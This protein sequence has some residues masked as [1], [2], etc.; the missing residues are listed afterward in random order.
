M[1]TRAG[2]TRCEADGTCWLRDG[3]TGGRLKTL[4]GNCTRTRFGN[5]YL[6]KMANLTGTD[7][8]C[9]DAVP[10]FQ[11]DVTSMHKKIYDGTLD[12]FADTPTV[13]EEF[14]QAFDFS[15]TNHK[16]LNVTVLFNDTTEVRR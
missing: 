12:R 7:F 14:A 3:E 11:S 9:I 5:C 13:L 8:E 16:K 2:L 1:T 6:S 15:D 4:S 10:A